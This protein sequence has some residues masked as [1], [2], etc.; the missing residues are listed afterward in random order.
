MAIPTK[1]SLL[2]PW[3]S[4]FDVKVT[5]NPLT[6]NL[7]AA[8][9]T[10]FHAAYTPYLAAYNALATAR[11][12]GTRS[13]VLTATKDTAKSALLR[14]A[15]ELYGIVQDS[16]SVSAA[17]KEDIGV[18][19]RKTTN[20]PVPPPSVAPGIAIRATIGNTVKLRL[21]DA[22]DSARRGKPA[23]VYGASVF[24]FIG[25]SAPTEESAWNFEGNTGLTRIDITFPSGTAAGAKV[26]FT[27]F[28]FN[29]RKQRGP[30]SNPAGTNL[31]GG[32]AM[33]A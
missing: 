12:A 21:F 6:Y 3:G 18:V 5:L 13:R 30:A 26:W 19:V 7:V 24:S 8:Q 2:V 9:A 4:N 14:V 10:S 11:E 15:R 32:A 23:G 22:A 28:W 17:N 33:A 1:D 31:P 16:N 25:A 20:S 27:A 29:Q